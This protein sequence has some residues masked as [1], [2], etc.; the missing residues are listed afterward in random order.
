MGARVPDAHE[1]TILYNYNQELEPESIKEFLPQFAGR[2]LHNIG[3]GAFIYTFMRV[4]DDLRSWWLL[5]VYDR[6]SFV[7]IVARADE[8]ESEGESQPGRGSGRNF[9][10]C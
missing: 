2:P 5:E 9:D 4:Q 1:V 7:V 6:H 10:F 8:Q 3:N